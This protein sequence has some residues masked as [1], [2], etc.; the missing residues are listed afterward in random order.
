MNIWLKSIFFALS[1]NF[2]WVYQAQA[3]INNRKDVQSFITQMHKRYGFNSAKLKQLFSQV[4]IQQDIIASMNRPY[5]KKN[6]DVY[7]KLFLTTQRINKGVEFWQANQK[8]LT[9]AEKQFGVPANIIVAILGIE[10]NYGAVQGKHRVIDALSTLAFA[11]PKRSKFFLS[12]LTHYLLLCKEQKID[13]LSL[14]GSYA[15]AMGKPQF[16]PSSYRSYAID[17]TGNGKKDLLHD[18]QD[19]IGSVANY[20]K[21][22]GWKVSQAITVPAKIE[23]TRY[24]RVNAMA[25]KA[26]YSTK[27]LKKYGITPKE[28]VSNEPKKAGLISLK[29]TDK[30]KEYWLAFP[31]FYVITRYNS[32]KQYAM[33]VY[34]LSEQLKQQWALNHPPKRTFA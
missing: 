5:E 22:H 23:G 34:L 13:P 32:S 4:S 25:K 2:L 17:Y 18:N 31:N 24:R 26:K 28:Y 11:Y 3:N 30:H 16:M 8:T 29:L 10:T 12:E 33:A 27:R 9:K 20:F 1:L 21:K 15:G 14:Y 19:V 6:W 7:K